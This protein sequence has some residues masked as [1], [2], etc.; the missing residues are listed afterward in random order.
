[1]VPN[2]FFAFYA[3]QNLPTPLEEF[4]RKVQEKIAANEQQNPR[5][6][7]D[8]ADSLNRVWRDIQRILHDRRLIINLNVA[9]FERLGECYGKMSALE[10]ACRDTMIPIE[11]EA[12]REFLEKFKHLRME[13]LSA[14]MNP[15]TVGNQLLEKLKE[16]VNAG[17]LDSRPEQILEESKRSV[18]VV[19]S[20]LE[21]LSDK[22]NNL[23]TAFLNRKIQLEQ[24]LILAQLTKDLIELEKILNKQR[25]EILGT[26]TLGESSRHAASILED[27]GTW[28]I[29]AVALRDKSL[30][31]TR[32]T[33]EVVKQGSFTGNEAC[34]KAYSVLANCTE[35]YDE[36]DLRESLLGQSKEFFTMAENVL[37][38]LDD[39]EA[40]LKRVSL[41]PGSPNIIPVHLK[42][43]Q[44]V[45]IAIN[46][47]LELGY[48]LIDEVG[49]TK[50]EVLGV[51]NIVE[52]IERRKL[53]L[54]TAFSKTSEK[55][56]KVSEELNRF[57]QQYNDIFQWI[58]SQKLEK[59]IN[60]PINFMGT[61]SNQ[62]KECLNVHQQLLREI[63]VRFMTVTLLLQLK[64]TKFFFILD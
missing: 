54:E 30:K 2:I 22:R 23:E 33:E 43:M 10:V 31:I 61:N 64:I 27:Y 34:A 26:F 35:Y 36:I 6:I 8:M 44:E 50:P 17:S 53:Y 4:Y 62:A 14:I 47:V 41:R 29:D 51:K 59:I 13:V 48:S 57:L 56:I 55:H 28:K 15:L 52:E 3:L 46:K 49:R 40:Q 7:E 20:W 21:D 39:L 63:E 12:V 60:G 45:S 37:L 16:I 32:T 1:M 11:V 58:E 24:C 25:D 9:F 18:I 42:L 19:E 38:R 5:L